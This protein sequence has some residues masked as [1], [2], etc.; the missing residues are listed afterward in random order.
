MQ[1]GLGQVKTETAQH[2]TGSGS[3]YGGTLGYA[4][5]KENASNSRVRPGDKIC[6]NSKIRMNLFCFMFNICLNS[7]VKKKK[8][9]DPKHT[10]RRMIKNVKL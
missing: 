3:V 6:L 8:I 1:F 7:V 9:T 10:A 5:L 4:D 2:P